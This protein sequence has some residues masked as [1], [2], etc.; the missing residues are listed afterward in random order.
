MKSVA[1]KKADSKQRIVFGEVYAPNRLDVDKE[2]MDV[3]GVR[4]MAYQFM[5]E[6]KMSLIDHMH[7]NELVSGAHVV[8]SFIARKGD[9][10]FI[11]GAWVVGVHIPGD[12]DW[13]QVE[14]G[15]W[16]GFSIEAFVNKEDIEV[17]IEIPSIIQGKTLKAD[18]GHEHSFY[19]SYSEDGDFRGGY[20]DEVNGHRHIIK[21]GTIT[22]TE[23]GHNH[24]FSH[25]ENLQLFQVGG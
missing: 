10:D 16:N 6:Q 18:D 7:T 1:I 17:E 19:V 2:F 20:T 8:E 15:A 3:E 14:S 5:R 11:E 12:E 4:K 13:G 21:R 24:R 9:P 22:E 23:V 25:V